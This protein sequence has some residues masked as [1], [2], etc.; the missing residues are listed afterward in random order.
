MN[1][2]S[3]HINKL[4][5]IIL[6]LSFMLIE[7]STC[8]FNCKNNIVYIILETV[9]L[10][11]TLKYLIKNKISIQKN[12]IIINSIFSFIMSI[13][14]D[15]QNK[16]QYIGKIDTNLEDLN[17]SSFGAIDILKVIF[18]F[19]IIF[20]IITAVEIKLKDKTN[21]EEESKEVN[22]KYGIKKWL[23][24]FL[25]IFIP[26]IIFL[27]IN[28]P[29]SVLADSFSS[30]YQITGYLKYNNHFPIMYTLFVGIFVNIGSTIENYNIGVA[31]YSITQ[32]SIIS[33]CIAYF[34]LW[35]KNKNIN[36]LY[37]AIVAIYF[38]ASTIFATYAITMWKDPL[39][40]IFL[41]MYMLKL[42]DIIETNGESLKNK[43]NV[44]SIIILNFLVAF[45]RNNGIFI[46]TILGVILTIKYI[47]KFKAFT[48][49]NILSIII[50]LII[51]GPIYKLLE[52]KTPAE[53]S[54]GIPI[55]QIAYVISEGGNISED[56]L[57]FL[58]ELLPIETWKEEYK[59]L[60][61]DSIKWAPGFNYTFLEN[62]KSEFIKVW[63][64]VCKNNMKESIKAY[65]LETYGFWSIETKNAYGFY[66]NY[67]YENTYDIHK[68]DLV[69]KTTGLD[70]TFVNNNIDFLGSGTLIWILL[71]VLTILIEN[72]QKKRILALLPALLVWTSIMI[73]TPVAFSLRYVLVLAY[74]LP[75]IIILP[76]I[77]KENKNERED[78]SINSMLQ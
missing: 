2:Q 54:L 1:K 69:K 6:M 36:K 70:L 50:I 56:D 75:F 16:V 14:I 65:L 38:A 45:L 42:Y 32:I 77:K 47:K 39:F 15:I 11:I 8:L 19:A 62:N 58:N 5:I 37:I 63:I 40:N 46:I 71:G 53:E 30:I 68:V 73:A 57:S 12:T 20:I 21:I 29:G 67:I 51:Q 78:S 26:Y 66:D 64:R 7:A 41:F 17:L 76:L 49:A 33:G 18:I 10:F 9:I 34:M 4:N 31:L 43:G 13:T 44:A 61:V 59:P 72:R 24:Y 55:Q 35:L 52:L 25:I 74:A 48:I 27:L 28:Y 60:V 22:Q 23:I 3:N